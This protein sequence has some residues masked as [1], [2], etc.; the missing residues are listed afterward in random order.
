MHINETWS[1]YESGGIN[2]FCVT[3]FDVFTNC[4]NFARANSNITV[5]PWVARTINNFSVSQNKV[6]SCRLCQQ[7][8]RYQKKYHE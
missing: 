7:R 2:C 4:Q 3:W 1:Y 6:V 8:G 5:V